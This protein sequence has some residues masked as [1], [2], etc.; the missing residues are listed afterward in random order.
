[1]RVRWIEGVVKVFSGED[2]ILCWSKCGII[3]FETTG[4]V[5]RSLCMYPL[6]EFPP[7]SG[8]CELPPLWCT[9]VL[10]AQL[11]VD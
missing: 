8:H 5:L 4:F 3:L 2:E 6:Q 1:M 7:P 9:D 11:I 10:M